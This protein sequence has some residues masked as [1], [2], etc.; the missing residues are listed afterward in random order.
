MTETR[1]RTLLLLALAAG[2]AGYV[3][4]TLIYFDLPPLPALAP[5][6]LTVL[7][8]LELIGAK[9][10]HDWVTAPQ[11]RGPLTALQVA[12]AVLLAKASSLSGSVL[13]GLYA[14]IFV[15]TFA[16]KDT[17][18]AAGHDAL[19]SGLSALASLLLVVTALVLERACRTPR[20]QE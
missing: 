3:L 5:S 17:Y 19:L 11:Q 1:L 20:L 2:A 12:R 4:A 15:W 18:A 9:A 8:L 6:G 14:G 10:I 7:A 13:V 16:R